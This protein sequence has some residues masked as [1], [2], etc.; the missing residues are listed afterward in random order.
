M[1]SCVEH[2]FKKKRVESDCMCTGK[3]RIHRIERPLVIK[4][5]LGSRI[6]SRN[7][8]ADT[9]RLQPV[10]HCVEIVAEYGGL[11]LTQN[12]VGAELQNN[13]IG[14]FAHYIL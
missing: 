8:N 5:K 2:P 1:T 13:K 14:A 7:Q 3:F 6:H 10:Y 12:I 9:P 4:P 11:N